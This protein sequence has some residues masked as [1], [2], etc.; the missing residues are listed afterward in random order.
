LMIVAKARG[1]TT[2][3]DSLAIT[4]QRF[5]LCHGYPSASSQE[6]GMPEV[7]MTAHGNGSA[8][9]TK[10]LRGSTRS[11]GSW[12]VY[13]A[14]YDG[15]RSEMYLD[16]VREA[17]GRSVGTSGLDGLRV[18]CDH[19]STFFLKGAIAEL[20]LFSCH[21]SEASR[22]QIEAALAL[23]YDLHL[24]SPP[25]MTKAQTRNTARRFRTTS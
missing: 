15:E 11:N 22:S 2:L 7:V 21:L 25:A 6:A 23:R 13:T 16:G 8:A 24:S 9:P 4:S 3:C 18:G 5:E 19:T 20:R 14:I 10:L 12:H 17:S 1:D